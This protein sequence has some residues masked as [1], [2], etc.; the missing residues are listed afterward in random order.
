MAGVRIGV[1]AA[2][3][4]DP[5]WNELIV[6]EFDALSPEGELVWKSI[7]PER[8]HWNF[9]PADT[10]LEFAEEQGFPTTVSHFVWDQ[11]TKVTGTPAWV[12]AI[13][14]PTELRKVLHEHMATVTERYGAKIR[15]W[16]AVNEPLQYQGKAELYPNHFYRVLGSDYIA[17]VFQIAHDESPDTELWLNEIFTEA[18]PAKCD[19]LVE[20]VADLVA[21]KVPIDGVG[22]QGHLF[23]LPPDFE[24]VQKTM[25]RIADLGLDVAITELD[26]PVD[27]GLA[28]KEE[29]SADRMAGIVHA[30][31]AV[32]R[33]NSITVW[34]LTDEVSW[35][36]WLLKPDMSPLLFDGKLRK[37][38]AY[39]TVRDA[40]VEGA[41]ARAALS[42]N[43]TP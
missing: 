1:A 14:D 9:E 31:L 40:L 41:A 30:C 23:P 24:L 20:V 17:E 28:D 11:A 26:A 19:K 36:N 3:K 16:I 33:C 5:G 7:H 29:V 4:P 25:Q 32:P 15:R 13:D 38:P 42:V 22:I 34:G 39:F 35:I 18:N 10:V 21:R 37:K 27:A 2:P 8:D 43:E 6:Q 12:R